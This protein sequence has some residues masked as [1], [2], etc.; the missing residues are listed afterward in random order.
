VELYLAEK[1]VLTTL[2]E[3]LTPDF[4]DV[5]IRKFS[6]VQLNPGHERCVEILCGLVYP[7][8]SISRAVFSRKIR[9]DNLIRA[10]HLIFLMSKFGN[11]VKFN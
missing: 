8:I 7:F 10:S 11:S 4:L 5:Q 1:S 9:A 2:F 6:Q 3:P